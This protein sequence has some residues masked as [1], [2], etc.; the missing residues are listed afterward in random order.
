MY[1]YKR[2][3][4]KKFMTVLL[5]ILY[6]NQL[7]YLCALAEMESILVFCLIYPKLFYV[8]IQNYVL[9]SRIN[10]SRL[11]NCQI[12]RTL[13]TTIVF[14]FCAIILFVFVQSFSWWHLG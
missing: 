9:T 7:F 3:K 12:N 5:W 10:N 1:V 2:K 6:Q 13:Q 8:K 14:F 4:T 11:V